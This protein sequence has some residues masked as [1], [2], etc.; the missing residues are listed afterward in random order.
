MAHEPSRRAFIVTAGVAAAASALPP[1]T[2]MTLD[3]PAPPVY[4]TA[5]DLITAL[6][7]REISARELLDLA[8]VPFR[9]AEV[10]SVA[11]IERP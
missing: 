5:N 4:R 6:A 3:D 1:R 11:Q 7:K 9:L 8:I 10:E 2:G